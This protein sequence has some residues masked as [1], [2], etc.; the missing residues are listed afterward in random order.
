MLT[1]SLELI[2]RRPV[3]MQNSSCAVTDVRVAQGRDERGTAA[4]VLSF[5]VGEKST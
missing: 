3:N 4:K 1:D 2:A 5:Y